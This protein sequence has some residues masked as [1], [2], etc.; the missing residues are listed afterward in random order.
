VARS[1]DYATAQ[2]F[3]A[4]GLGVSLVPRLGLSPHVGGLAIRRVR[5][6]EP[7]RTV[8]AAVRETSLDQPPVR[9]LL[10]AL[11]QPVPVDIPPTP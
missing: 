10:A 5:R 6:P 11:T 7:V 1:E 9:T 4:A 8:V 2:H 3:V